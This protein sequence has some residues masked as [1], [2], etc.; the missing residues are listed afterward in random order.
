MKTTLEERIIELWHISRTALAGS[1]TSRYAR[2]CYI[3]NEL[4]RSY[5]ELIKDMSGKRLWLT[6]EDQIS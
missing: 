4:I 6:I 3:K 2:M 5:P 1:D